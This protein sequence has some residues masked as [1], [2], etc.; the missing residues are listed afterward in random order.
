MAFA[1]NNRNKKKSFRPYGVK[2]RQGRPHDLSVQ[3]GQF[4]T[5][6]NA[7]KEEF[8]FKVESRRNPFY[9][10]LR[11]DEVLLR[12]EPVKVV[13]ISWF[14]PAAPVKE[15]QKSTRTG[16]K[17]DT[18]GKD[19]SKSAAKG[20]PKSAGGAASRGQAGAAK[21]K[22][23]GAGHGAAEHSGNR[24]AFAGRAH[25]H[26]TAGAERRGSNGHRRG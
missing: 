16:E 26:G 4:V 12:G 7:K 1:G 24:P 22:R 9:G 21:R 20:T 11:G 10:K 19:G 3:I 17:R 18:A 23:E 14:D 13:R 2:A 6:K 5:V 8:T 25:R 15:E